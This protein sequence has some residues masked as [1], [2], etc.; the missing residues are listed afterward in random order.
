MLSELV[1]E[2]E[3]MVIRIAGINCG[4]EAL[5]GSDSFP[6]PLQR[7]KQEKAII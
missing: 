6:S 3:V 5:E 7:A 4:N 2:E 1:R